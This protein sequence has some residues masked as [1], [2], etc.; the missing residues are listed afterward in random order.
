MFLEE[1]AETS[2][3]AHHCVDSIVKRLD[4]DL[5]KLET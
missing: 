5:I 3:Q 1:K 4:E 2:S